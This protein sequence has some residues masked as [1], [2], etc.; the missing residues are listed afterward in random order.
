MQGFFEFEIVV[1]SVPQSNKP[2]PVKVFFFIFFSSH[3]FCED[4]S[5]YDF[6]YFIQILFYY[7]ASAKGAENEPWSVPA[8]ANVKRK[9]SWNMQLERLYQNL[10]LFFP[11][12]LH[13]GYSV[14]LLAIDG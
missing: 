13:L 10:W 8:I 6:I 3:R 5:R 14:A 12:R 2:N 11:P 1:A 4:C 9:E 7:A